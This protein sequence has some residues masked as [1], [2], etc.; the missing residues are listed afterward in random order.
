MGELCGKESK[1][2]AGERERGEQSDREGEE[3]G[4][5]SLSYL[6]KDCEIDGEER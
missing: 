5:F 2:E 4:Y 1:R 6:V 3:R